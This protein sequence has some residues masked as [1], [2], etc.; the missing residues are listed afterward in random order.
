MKWSLFKETSFSAKHLFFGGVVFIKRS[1][2]Q[3]LKKYTSPEERVYTIYDS[4]LE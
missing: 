2:K 3:K 4:E 1:K